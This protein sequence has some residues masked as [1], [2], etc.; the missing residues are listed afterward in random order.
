MCLYFPNMYLF[1]SVFIFNCTLV[2]YV[3]QNESSCV[4]HLFR[5]IYTI[6]KGC[7]VEAEKLC[8][9]VY[10]HLSKVLH[11]SFLF[12]SNFSH[13]FIRQVFRWVSIPHLYFIFS[14]KCILAKLENWI[15]SLACNDEFLLQLKFMCRC[16]QVYTGVCGFIFV[17]C[18]VCIS[19]ALQHGNLVSWY[20][21][22]KS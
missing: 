19:H 3:M 5:A 9:R 10:P 14:S 8:Y 21:M 12:I 1:I 15:F 6:V 7:T 20:Y 13:V 22:Q 18:V 2:F 4:G 11:L 17:C 16:M